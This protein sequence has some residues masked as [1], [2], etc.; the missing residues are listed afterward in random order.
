MHHD[1]TRTLIHISRITDSSKALYNGICP[2]EEGSIKGGEVYCDCPP[3][4]TSNCQPGFDIPQCSLMS[5][6]TAYKDVTKQYLDIAVPGQCDT[7]TQ[8]TEDEPED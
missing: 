8:I 6:G 4:D 3:D 5:E 2:G 1:I 7:P